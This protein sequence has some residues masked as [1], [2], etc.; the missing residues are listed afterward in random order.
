VHD[1]VG[2]FT[3]QVNSPGLDVTVYLRMS[4]P[5]VLVGAKKETVAAA[6]LAATV[7]FVGGL[8]TVEGVT[9][10]DA[11]DAADVP[12]P[13]VALTLN[14]YGEPFVNPVTLQVS[15]DAF[16]VHVPCALLLES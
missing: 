9:A 10:L 2:A 14:V 7:I 3:V 8:G 13:F 4:E 5:P 16:V 11:L 1:L 12:I 15:V 6:S